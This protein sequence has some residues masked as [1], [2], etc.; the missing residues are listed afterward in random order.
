V[1]VVPYT[2]INM[3]VGLDK[4]LLSHCTERPPTA[5]RKFAEGKSCW[6]VCV[7]LN[8]K[9]INHTTCDSEERSQPVPYKRFFTSI[10]MFRNFAYL[11]TFD[12]MI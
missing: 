4:I 3:D 9:I 2:G 5:F 11:H 6:Y 7:F 12:F 10:K 1:G 8:Q